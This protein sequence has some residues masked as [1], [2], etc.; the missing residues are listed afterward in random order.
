MLFVLENNELKH[1]IRGEGHPDGKP[2]CL[3]LA[4]RR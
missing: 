4:T 2:R 3:A 1:G